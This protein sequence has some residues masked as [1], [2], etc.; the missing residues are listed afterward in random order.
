[1]SIKIKAVAF[2]D[3][4]QVELVERETPDLRP[5]EVL[6]KVHAVALCTM[7]QRLFTGALK[8]PMLATGGHEVS[9]EIVAMGSAV[10]KK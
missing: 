4:K 3:I 9:G 1:M 10:N 6:V 5:D 8:M 7:E 2:K